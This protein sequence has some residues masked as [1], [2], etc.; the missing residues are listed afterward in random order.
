MWLLCNRARLKDSGTAMTVGQILDDPD[1]YTLMVA[2]FNE[3]LGI[4]RR[5][6]RLLITA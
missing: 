5:V 3:L 2:V 4:A 6:I 1:S